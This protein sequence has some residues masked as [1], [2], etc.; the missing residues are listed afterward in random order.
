ML[1]WLVL[2]AVLLISVLLVNYLSQSLIYPR[3]R[4]NQWDQNKYPIE[5]SEGI[6]FIYDRNSTNSLSILYSHGNGCNITELDNMREYCREIGVNLLIYD[7][8]GYGVSQDVKFLGMNKDVLTRSISIAYSVLRKRTYGKIVLMGQS[9]GCYPTLWLASHVGSH[10]GSKLERK[11]YISGVILCVPFD[12]LSNVIHR[13]TG[14]SFVSGL[15]EEIDNLALMREIRVPTLI[16]SAKYD[17][18]IPPDSASNLHRALD[19]PELSQLVNV[20]SGHN[21]YLT[22]D[23]EDKITAY[24]QTL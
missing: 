14:F 7:Y 1:L 9:L 11:E 4:F 3:P 23:V 12:K 21:D 16:F 24:L 10:V 15:T 5:H 17:T 22:R 8:F 13:F 6:A 2:L 19:N 20:K 18:I